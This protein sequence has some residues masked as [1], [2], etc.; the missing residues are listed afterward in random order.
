MIRLFNVYFSSRMLLLAASEALLIVLALLSA[1]TIRAGGDAEFGLFQDGALLRIT[2]AT[3]VV[4]L[5]MHYYDLYDFLSLRRQGEVFA[6][7]VQVL[8]LTSIILACL[9]YAY[10]EILPERTSF[11]IWIVATAFISILWRRLFSA[12]TNS[13]QLSQRTML[14]GAGPITMP[15]VSELAARPEFGMSVVGYLESQDVPER[16]IHGLPCLGSFEELPSLIRR[17]HIRRVIV[18][19]SSW[20]GNLA[21]LNGISI[22]QGADV[23][24]A[25]TGK[26]C[27]NLLGPGQLMLPDDYSVSRLLL[28]Y[29]RIASILISLLGLLLAAPIMLIVALMV[30]LDSRGP[31]I[32]RQ[33][34]VGKNSRTFTIYK[35]RS[36][37]VD[38]DAGGPPR[39]AMQIDR[40]ITRVGRWLRRLRID[41]L[42]Q[43]VNILLGDMDLIGPRPFTPHEESGLE[44]QIAGYSQRWLVKPGAT[45]WAQ[46]N[47]GYCMSI[48]DN[49]DKLSYDLFYI[50]NM[51]IGLDCLILFQSLK[52]ILLG[53]GGH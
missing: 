22:Q 47:R 46:V 42:P 30:R 8:G 3:F 48:E 33:S 26:V 38:A 27:L 51:S 5:C 44:K 43:L 23:Y 29:K 37:R 19:N 32:F 9:Y 45:G 40:R 7:L 31:V 1:T 21:L 13:T 25:I 10:P 14:L 39:P 35:F 49:A 12:V 28:F 36:M 20:G 17:E 50:K 41:E 11:V 18:T 34:R 15:L 6:R 16:Q 2:V 24:E 52:I 4:V 53:R